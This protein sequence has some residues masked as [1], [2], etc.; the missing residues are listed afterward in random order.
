MYRAIAVLV[1][2]FASLLSLCAPEARA[3]EWNEATKVTFNEPVEIPGRVL[4]AGTYWFTVL[5]DDPEQNVVQVWNSTRQHLISMIMTV[6][7]YRAQFSG[8]PVLKFEERASNLPEAVRAW[9]YPGQN[10]G[11]AFVYS[12][13]EARKLAKRTG[14]PILSM[15]DDVASNT[16]KPA[17]SAKE[18]SVTA[19]KNTPVNA[20]T[21]NGQQVDKSQAIEAAPNQTTASRH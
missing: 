1:C 6:P 17:K 18:P 8:H 13:T 10:Y 19:M 20:I 4:N 9:F 5:R 16:T 15:R 21:P 3:D 14:Q 2:F 7:D 12:E 11:H